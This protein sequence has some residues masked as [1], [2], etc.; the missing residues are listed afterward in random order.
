VASDRISAWR[1]VPA[2]TAGCTPIVTPNPKLRNPK[3]PRSTLQI[4]HVNYISWSTKHLRENIAL[5]EDPGD[6]VAVTNVIRQLDWKAL[7]ALLER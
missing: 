2:G 7:A 4:L 5:R 1:L 3:L 6:C